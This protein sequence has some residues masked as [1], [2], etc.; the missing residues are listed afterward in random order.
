MAS[1]CGVARAGVRVVAALILL[2]IAWMIG[3][4]L[5]FARGCPRL[6]RSWP[7]PAA[8]AKVS[9][10]PPL[11]AVASPPTGPAGDLAEPLAFLLAMFDE[12]CE[13]RP[14]GAGRTRREAAD[15]GGRKGR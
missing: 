7:R 5:S 6:R 9:Q 4:S 13:A 2:G 8:A 14:P 1:D 11:E 15:T 10:V 12:G 3:K